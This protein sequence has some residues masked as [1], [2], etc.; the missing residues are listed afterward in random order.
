MEGQAHL[1]PPIILGQSVICCNDAVFE[2]S[3]AFESLVGLE[4]RIGEL[5]AM[6]Q[7]SRGSCAT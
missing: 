5:I 3:I 1:V 6:N 2:G 7:L 4:G